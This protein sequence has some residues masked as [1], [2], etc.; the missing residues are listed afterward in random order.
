MTLEQWNNKI[1][2]RFDKAIKNPV[3]VQV[4]GKF[5]ERTRYYVD[6]SGLYFTENGFQ[7]YFMPGYTVLSVKDDRLGN[8][9]TCKKYFDNVR[10]GDVTGYRMADTWTE[11]TLNGSHVVRLSC[12]KKT[13]F[14]EQTYYAFFNPKFLK[15]IPKSARFFIK[16]SSSPMVVYL[17]GSLRYMIAIIFPIMQISIF[18][19]EE[20]SE[21]KI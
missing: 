13:E 10:F 20:G 6:D 15:N 4:N 17:D 16:D 9:P 19:Q 18:Q 21:R 12:T 1:G 11:G 2:K 14:S 5:V 7:I 3:I 8:F